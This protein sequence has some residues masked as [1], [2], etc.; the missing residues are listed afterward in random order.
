MGGLRYVEHRLRPELQP[1]VECLWLASDPRARPRAP[2]RVVPDGCPELILHLLD[3]FARQRGG[4]FVVQPRAFLAGTLTQPWLLRAGRRV[5]TFGVHFRPGAVTALLPVSM[6]EATDRETRLAAIVGTAAATALGR[7][8]RTARSETS[9]FAAVEEWLVG[10]L[11]SARSRRGDGASAGVRLV[12]ESRGACRIDDVARALGWTRRRLERT[13]TRE[14]GIRPK[15]FARIVRLNAV[16]AVLDAAERASAV[17]MALAAGS[18]DQAH[19]LRDFRGLAG[20]PPGAG[21]ELDGEL[22]RHFTHP[23]RLRLLFAGE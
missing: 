10:R 1:Y 7:A 3:R 16:L 19:L 12:L 11:A 21:R 4:R 8:L 9:R 6:P 13:F 17:D 2:E 15:L 18:F 20:R 22:A 5:L 23:E 14:L